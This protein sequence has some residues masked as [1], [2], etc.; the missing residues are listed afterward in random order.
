MVSVLAVMLGFNDLGEVVDVII[1]WTLHGSIGA[2]LAVLITAG[3]IAHFAGVS[4]AVVFITATV[5]E[6]VVLASFCVFAGWKN[7]KFKKF[8][9]LQR[10]G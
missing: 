1:E 9:Q 6:F 4:V 10:E 3:F 8:T 2:Y 7:Y 5:C